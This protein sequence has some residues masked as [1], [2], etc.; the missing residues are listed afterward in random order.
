MKYEFDNGRS[1]DDKEI[2]MLNEWYKPL[3][4]SEKC[5]TEANRQLIFH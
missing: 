5:N 3:L 1:Y 4:N 2:S